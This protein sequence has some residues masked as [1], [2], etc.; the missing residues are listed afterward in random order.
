MRSWQA[1]IGGRRRR[2]SSSL[3]DSGTPVAVPGRGLPARCRAYSLPSRCSPHSCARLSSNVSGV[4]HSPNPR[5]NRD[6]YLSKKAPAPDA[7][8]RARMQG[9]FRGFPARV[10]RGPNF[11]CKLQSALGPR[12]ANC[13]CA[14]VFFATT[15]A[16]GYRCTI[17]P[18]A[19]QDFCPRSTAEHRRRRC[20]NRT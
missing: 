20:N 2:G 3:T 15:A 19:R 16:A 11:P 10:V 1:M 14:L 12:L 13:N 17:N 6:R 5:R 9:R 7:S 4:V 18:T 8:G